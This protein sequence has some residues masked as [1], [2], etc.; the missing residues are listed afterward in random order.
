MPSATRSRTTA[1]C[2]T[3]G[4]GAG[5]TASRR[6]GDGSVE[7][8]ALAERL[9]DA[10]AG[11]RDVIEL[12]GLALRQRSS[13]SRRP[14]QRLRRGGPGGGARVDG[15]ARRA[16]PRRRGAAPGAAPSPR[17][18]DR[19]VGVTAMDRY[20]LKLYV[21]GLTTRSQ[22]A[23]GHAAAALRRGAGR[24]LRAARR[25][26]A[27]AARAGRVRQGPGHPDGDQAAARAASAGSSATCPTRPASWP[28]STFEPSRR[29]AGPGAARGRLRR[30]PHVD[31]QAAHRD[32]R[33]RPH[34]LRRLARGRDHAGRRLLRQRQ[35][36]L[37]RPVPGR[38]DHA[39]AGAGRLRHLRG[40]A[41]GPAEQL[42]RPRLGHRRLG[43]RG[44]LGLRRRLARAGRAADLRR[45]LRPG[46]PDGP[47]RA[48][49]PQ[50]RRPAAG[51]RRPGQRLHPVP[52]RGDRPL[53]AVPADPVAP[54]ASGSRPSSPPSAA[55]ST[56]RSR[57]SASRSSSRT[58]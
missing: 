58:T 12:H 52:R 51:A 18:A 14:R 19:R 9:A 21:T 44:P 50:G 17:A 33:L 43:G 16:L 23:D 57:A 38:R 1:G 28:R 40:V 31:H 26:R 54:R 20:V 8:T 24:P 27:G 29:A 45:R 55:R 13:G 22:R 34:R 56:A 7:L 25:R 49:R 46:G 32:P 41:R 10:G 53:R 30:L 6:P 4:S 42:R 35:D 36:G 2:S 11:P 39:P 47:H 5:A 48:R 15:P 37:R 3:S